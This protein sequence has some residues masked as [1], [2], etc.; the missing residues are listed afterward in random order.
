LGFPDHL[1]EGRPFRQ[2]KDFDPNQYFNILTHLEPT[3][4]YKLD[5]LY[6]T[7]ELASL[8][9]VYVRKSGSAPFQSYAEFLKSFGEEIRGERSYKQ[10]RHKFDYLEKIVIDQSPESYFEFVT[11]AILGDQFYL[12]G[13]ALYKDSKILCDISDQQ[14]VDADMQDFG[15]EFPQDVKARIGEMDLSPAVVVDANT[16][17]VRFVTFTKWGGFFENV[18]VMDKKNPMQV[19][20]TEFNPLIEYDCRIVF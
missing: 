15:I 3:A 12:S 18:Y 1:T 5:F 6:F 19:R 13:Q 20:D 8:P 4:G 11:L 14:Y 9:L 17:T 10:L 16:V 7:D 2:G